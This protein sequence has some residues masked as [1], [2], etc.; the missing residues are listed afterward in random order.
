M[1]HAIDGKRIL[2]IA[3]RV[4]AFL[5]FWSLVLFLLFTL[6]NY[7]RFLDADQ[8]F[9]MDLLTAALVLHLITGLFYLLF[10]V[11]R[12]D[13][14]LHPRPGRLVF[15]IV[16]LSFSFLLMLVLVSFS[17]WISFAL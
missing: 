2:F 14:S 6:S 15:M 10:P 4:N 3:G 16:S 12:R 7:Q 5:F 1:R 17:V 11:L 9:I 13:A 8:R